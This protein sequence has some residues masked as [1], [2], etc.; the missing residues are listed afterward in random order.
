MLEAGLIIPLMGVNVSAG[1][2]AAGHIHRRKFSK[3]LRLSKNHFFIAF[4]G[5]FIFRYYSFAGKY[6]AKIIP[7][8]CVN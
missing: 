1:A 4:P 8:I 7:F 3:A 6:D 5:G 2:K